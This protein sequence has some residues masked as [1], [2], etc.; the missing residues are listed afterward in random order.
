MIQTS[1]DAIVTCIK[2]EE[3]VDVDVKSDVSVFVVGRNVPFC[4]LDMDEVYQAYSSSNKDYSFI[5]NTILLSS[6]SSSVR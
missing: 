6:S 4:A 1:I 2:A 5:R 3:E